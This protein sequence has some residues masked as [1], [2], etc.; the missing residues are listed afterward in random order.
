MSIWESQPLPEGVLPPASAPLSSLMNV[1]PAVGWAVSEGAV[2]VAGEEAPKSAATFGLEKGS[3]TVIILVDGLG[4]NQLLEKTGYVRTL[5]SLGSDPVVAQTCAPST[6][7]SALTAF[8]TGALPAQ[9]NMVG[10]SV[11]QGSSTMNLIQ[12]RSGVD[13]RAWQPVPTYFER[14]AAAGISSAVITDPK[15]AGSGLT[16]AA[17]RGPKF[18]PAVALPERFEGALRALRS[19]TQ[20]CYVY[21]AAID[22]AGHTYGPQSQQWSEALEDFDSALGQFLLRLP[23]GVQVVLS[24]DHGMVQV[25]QRVDVAESSM[26]REGVRLLAGE[27]RAAHVHA[28]PGQEEAVLARWRNYWGD[29]AW[30]FGPEDFSQVLGQGPGLELVGAA[31]VMPKGQTVVVDS[32]TQSQ[33]AI[34]MKGV[35]GSLTAAEMQIPVWRLA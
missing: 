29:R 19:G 13:A 1:L 27:G 35:H 30:V 4:L 33:A 21:W 28:E 9:T 16:N 20:I 34:A 12:F 2:D 24:A 25:E 17:M 7:S 23:P 32:R 11:A 10:Y 14:F 8:A 6:T 3:P 26:L 15:F 18:V 22:K 31:L 5:R